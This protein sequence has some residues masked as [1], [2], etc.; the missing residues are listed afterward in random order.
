MK[1]VLVGVSAALMLTIGVFGAGARASDAAPLPKDYVCHH[2]S[3]Q[4]NPVVI[5]N[6]S[7]NAVPHHLA[8]HGGTGPDY[9]IDQTQPGLTSADCLAL[10]APGTISG[11]AYADTQD[12]DGVLDS[13]ETGLGGV[14][15][16]LSGSD[17]LGNA[18]S[19]SVTTGDDGAYSF[20]VLPGTYDVS[21][22]GVDFYNPGTANDA[23]AGST[24]MPGE[25][26]GIA[27]YSN[28]NVVANLPEEAED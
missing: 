5:I 4:T 26:S 13:G 20:D 23:P 14:V 2:T 3:S 6:I 1:R 22:G 25:I 16:T 19:A 12:S 10:D 17:Y 9:V 27:V 11:I 8:L 21:Y 18:V 7:D 15:V 24:A 28:Q